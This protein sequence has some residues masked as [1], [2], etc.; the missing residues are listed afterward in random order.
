MLYTVASGEQMLALCKFATNLC[1]F[2]RKWEWKYWL[3]SGD[4]NCTQ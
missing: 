4:S 1:R 3:G 2:S